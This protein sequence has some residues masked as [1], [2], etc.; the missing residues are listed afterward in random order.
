MAAPINV[1]RLCEFG[2]ID[3]DALAEAY[4]SW[5]DEA[6]A[7]VIDESDL[8]VARAAELPDELEHLAHQAAEDADFEAEL[9]E[10]LEWV[11]DMSGW[12]PCLPLA[13]EQ[14]CDAGVLLPW[15]MRGARLMTMPTETGPLLDYLW[16]SCPRH[17]A[18]HLC[19]FVYWMIRSERS[20]RLGTPH[21]SPRRQAMK[22]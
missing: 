5:V 6:L 16:R 10:W 13:L 11:F 21:W 7:I 2:A 17:V 15:D 1:Q 22:G 3:S 8:G 14:S 18:A 12:D 19:L 9:E 4:D 20:R